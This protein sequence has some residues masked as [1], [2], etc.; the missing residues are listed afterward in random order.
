M[1]IASSAK[2]SEATKLLVVT[3]LSLVYNKPE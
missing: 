1:S 2:Y 3:D